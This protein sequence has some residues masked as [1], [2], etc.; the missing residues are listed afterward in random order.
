MRGWGSYQ[1][2][3]PDAMGLTPPGVP[4][5]EFA[6]FGA[7]HRGD[8]LPA[9]ERMPVDVVVELGG[10]VRP[11]HDGATQENI[12]ER[13]QRSMVNHL[14]PAARERALIPVE[15]EVHPGDLLAHRLDLA[16]VPDPEPLL[17]REPD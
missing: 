4:R 7:A 9:D 16:D 15:A 2:G 14:L 1:A 3:R 10:G 12:L 8:A 13:F 11:R 17:V 6:P 5:E